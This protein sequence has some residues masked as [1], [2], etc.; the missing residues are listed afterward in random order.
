M[1]LLLF[2]CVFLQVSASNAITFSSY[3]LVASGTE[4]ATWKLRG[5]AMAGAVF[6]VG[7]HT[8]APRIAR[9]IQDTLS[10][11]KLFTLLFV[12]CCRFAA[13]AGNIRV[14]RPNNF[15]NSFGY[16]NV[17][18]FA[19]VSKDDFIAAKVT[20][21]ATLFENIFGKSAGTRVLPALLTAEF[22]YGYKPQLI[23]IARLLQEL[24]KDGVLPF[25][26]LF[27]E[28]RP[29]RTPIYA[30]LLHLGVTILF[31][32]APPAG[33]A[34]NF[35]V[36]LSSYPTTVLL[37]A[38]TIGLVK[39]RFTDRENFQSPLRA[40]WILIAIYLVANIFLIVMPF[41]RPPNGKGSTSLPYWLTSVVALAILSLGIVY[42][43][44]RFVVVP[45]LFGYSHQEIQQKLS[46][47]SKV[48]RFQRVKR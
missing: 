32:C 33:D 45:R 8:I 43:T 44:L 23:I 35:I 17:N 19:A 46:D 42:Y 15:T 2:Y 7:I 11:V 5:V 21:A 40:P 24:A 16:D 38:I 48:T 31:T 1:F 25:S 34:F 22:L 12:V 18:A 29:F 9:G 10:A 13:L 30:L 3:I 39:L 36:S 26:N 6:A 41:V 27:M 14:E 20:V 4:S 37:T 47:G 28:N